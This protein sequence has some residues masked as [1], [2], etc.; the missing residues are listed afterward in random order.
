MLIIHSSKLLGTHLNV[1]KKLEVPTNTPNQVHWHADFFRHDNS[2]IYYV[3]INDAN[4]NETIAIFN[5]EPLN[6]S[7]LAQVAANRIARFYAQTQNKAAFDIFQASSKEIMVL[8]DT[9]KQNFTVLTDKIKEL[10]KQLKAQDKINNQ[11]PKAIQKTSVTKTVDQ[12]ARKFY[13][14]L[15]THAVHKNTKGR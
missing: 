8:P 14:G 9:N 15:M 2:G 12:H 5:N 4:P 11:V 13:G 7:Q 1:P 6:Y 10:K 3:L